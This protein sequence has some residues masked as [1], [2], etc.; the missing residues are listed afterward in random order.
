MFIVWGT[1]VV[2]RK[3]GR[4]ADYCYL[5]RGFRPFHL[6]RIESVGHLYYIPLGRRKA[7]G[8]RRTC[9]Q[10]KTSLYNEEP[11][12]NGIASKDRH[13]DLDALIAKTNPDIRT[14][15]AVRLAADQRMRSGTLAADERRV[16]LREPFLMLN[17]RAVERRA[18]TQ[19]DGLSGLGCLAT[20][21]IPIA[22]IY[23]GFKLLNG[24]NHASVYTAMALA[25]VL[26]GLT[27][28][29]IGRDTRRFVGRTLL[30]ILVR[31]LRP[32]NP[33]PEEIEETLSELAQRGV[34]IAKLANA[35]QLIEAL[36]LPYH[37]DFHIN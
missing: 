33:R 34:V 29:A 4:I 31:S 10:C 18:E 2:H 32:L 21:A 28:V 19:L 12:E 36:T 16:Y 22:V 24:P 23:L 6:A 13:D 7:L 27:V 1:K 8:S 17:A 15:Y 37:D 14:Q 3:L 30:P 9:E 25:L 35:N 20:V 5:C 26:A 11:P